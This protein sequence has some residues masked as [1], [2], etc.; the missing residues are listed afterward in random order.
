[1]TAL[2]LGAIRSCLEGAIPAIMAPCTR[3]GVP[4]VA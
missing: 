2:T 4:N 1:M 3:N